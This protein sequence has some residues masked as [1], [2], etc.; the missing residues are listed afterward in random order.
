MSSSSP[1]STSSTCKKVNLVDNLCKRI[2]KSSQEAKLKSIGF[3][4][5]T[6]ET[7]NSKSSPLVVIKPTTTSKPT[8]TKSDILEKPITDN[9]STSLVSY[10]SSDEDDD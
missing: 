4:I 7:N 9:V 5:S 2:N 1:A 10:N 6:T 3:G 8:A